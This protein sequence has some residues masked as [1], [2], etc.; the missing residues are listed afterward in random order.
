MP[1]DTP[2]YPINRTAQTAIAPFAWLLTIV[3]WTG[4]W[5]EIL[6]HGHWRF[7]DDLSKLYLGIMGAYAS[8]AEISKWLVNEPTDPGQDPAFERI[9]RGG[10]FI[11]LWLAPLLCALVW[12]VI[13][14]S[15]PMPTPL[16]RT[17]GG[18]IGI[19][20]VKAASRHLRHK[21]HG[22]FQVES[23]N[24]VIEP[25][26]S[27]AP[28]EDFA[29]TLY[30][31]IAAAPQGLAIGELFAAFSD[32]SKPRLYRALDKLVKSNRLTR[33]G[34]PRTPDV[35]YKARVAIPAVPAGAPSQN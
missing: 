8:A 32:D 33:T 6:T 19:F 10:F 24:V 35:R 26:A 31:R 11:A 18:L 34:K 12:R 28:E 17:V 25:S 9:H 3:L 14:L 22:I 20:F 29:E 23:D 27:S 15:I 30:Q 5:M 21:K 1:T 7:Q 13:D 16:Q 2:P 4:T